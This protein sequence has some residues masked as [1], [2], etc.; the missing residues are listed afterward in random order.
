MTES[1]LKGLLLVSDLWQGVIIANTS[2]QVTATVLDQ[3][4]HAE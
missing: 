3:K 2:R 4:N 1:C